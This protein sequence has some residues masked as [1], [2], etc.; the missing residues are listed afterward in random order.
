M[1]DPA[2]TLNSP[3]DGVQTRTSGPDIDGTDLQT[4]VTTAADA[5]LAAVNVR[6][7]LAGTPPLIQ[8]STLF[9]LADRRSVDMAVRGYLAHIDPETGRP[10]AEDTLR[11]AGFRGQ[12]AELLFQ[13]EAPIGELSQSAVTAWFQDPDH[14]LI[15]LSPEFRF[16]GIGIMGDGQRWIVTMIMAGE[17]P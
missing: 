13:S 12:V 1:D 10:L 8:Q 9:E 14:D 11:E 5:L 17:S 2:A 16:A 3:I 4:A 7:A 6:R 15:L